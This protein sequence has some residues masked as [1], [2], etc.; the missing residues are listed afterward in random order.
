MAVDEDVANVP[1]DFAQFV[2]KPRADPSHLLELNAYTTRLDVSAWGVSVVA[3]TP[4]RDVEQL[5]W[6]YTDFYKWSVLNSAQGKAGILLNVFSSSDFKHKEDFVF[7]T[8]DAPRLATTI[9]YVVCGA[10]AA[11]TVLYPRR[12]ALTRPLSLSSLPRYYIEKF[13]SRMSLRREI[14]VLASSAQYYDSDDEVDDSL[15][16]R[17]GQTQL[18]RSTSITYEDGWDDENDDV[19]DEA[20][21]RDERAAGYYDDPDGGGGSGGEGSDDEEGGFGVAEGAEF[22]EDAAPVPLERKP[23]RTKRQTIGQA[24][25]KAM[26]GWYRTLLLSQQ[27]TLFKDDRLELQLQHVYAHGLARLTVVCRVPAAAS[28]CTI[29]A[30]DIVA[31]QNA[32]RLDVPSEGDRSVAPG[33][34]TGVTFLI[35]LMRPFLGS[36]TLVL[37]FLAGDAPCRYS[38]PLPMLL[39]HFVEPVSLDADGFE[40]KWAALDIADAP[41]LKASAAVAAEGAAGLSVDDA[42][43]LLTAMHL[44]VVVVEAAA[45]GGEGDDEPRAVSYGPGDTVRAS[46][47]LHTSA[48]GESGRPITVGCMVTI[49]VEGDAYR[50]SVRTPVA[51]VTTC[52]LRAWVTQVLAGVRG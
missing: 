20:R 2:V 19:V 10:P 42:A 34:Q 11:P 16:A 6:C 49:A 26:A 47:Q 3:V 32:L 41:D 36:P 43:M 37:D 40:E 18:R 14:A 12:P 17:L 13:M 8:A 30:S 4:A 24:Q 23:A 22:E 21:Q 38:V 31:P 1:D 28:G 48:V 27:G 39:S 44:G 45:D 25:Q 7:R 29:E 52:L 46:G 9:E 15:D 5:F 35:Q 33:G 51:G 50:L